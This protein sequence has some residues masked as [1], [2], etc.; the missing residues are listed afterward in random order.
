MDQSGVE[1]SSS[2]HSVKITSSSVSINDGA[3]EVT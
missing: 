3:L 1:I 2:G